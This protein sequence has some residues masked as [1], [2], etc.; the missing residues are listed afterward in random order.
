MLEKFTAEEI[1]IIKKE[2]KQY[3]G[4]TSSKEFFGQEVK[5]KLKE[6]FDEEVYFYNLL[7]PV[8]SIKQALLSIADYTFAN[9]VKDR[10]RV[11]GYDPYKRSIHIA[12]VEAY[13]AFVYEL[14][15]I[16]RQNKKDWGKKK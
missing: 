5:E 3:E 4:T 12:N 14:I 15:E 8:E 13:K 10:K 6:I 16:I 7:N 9:F 2:L 1:E 11:S